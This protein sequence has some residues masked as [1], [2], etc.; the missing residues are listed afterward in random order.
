[1]A[2]SGSWRVFRRM[3][4]VPQITFGQYR[5]LLTPPAQEPSKVIQTLYKHVVGA[6][7]N[8]DP[9]FY[10]WWQEKLLKILPTDQSQLPARRMLDSFDSA[11]IP[12]ASDL[13][14]R[15]K[16]LGS[17]GNIRVGRLLEDMDIFSVHLV[18]KHVQNPLRPA[19]MVVSPWMIVTGL[20]DQIDFTGVLRPDCDIRISG[21]VTW[22]GQSSAETTLHLEQAFD[23]SWVKIT[24][25]RFVLVAR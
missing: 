6:S 4:S 9:K 8:F 11:I 22:V 23:G 10:D 12:V 17:S 25:A 20:V 3:C 2:T 5:C 1:M 13:E 21:H 24:E 15:E 16:Y 19:D 14:F 7:K 18:Y